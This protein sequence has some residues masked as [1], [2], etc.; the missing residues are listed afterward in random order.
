MKLTDDLIERIDRVSTT[1]GL[2]NR[3]AVIKFCVS[4]FLDHFDAKGETAL[5]LNWR[6]ILKDLDQRKH[7]YDIGPSRHAAVA[8]KKEQYGKKEKKS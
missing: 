7:R 5:P 1:T 8:E 3:S 4:S 6:E 2:N